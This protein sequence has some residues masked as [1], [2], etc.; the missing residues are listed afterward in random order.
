ME[1]TWAWIAGSF[2]VFFSVASS[3]MI[4]VGVF[5]SIWGFK[6]KKDTN[7]DLRKKIHEDII[8]NFTLFFE[9]LNNQEKMK[10]S[11]VDIKLLTHFK[12]PITRKKYR[13]RLNNLKKLNFDQK[14]IF[15]QFRDYKNI[16]DDFY[17]RK[18]LSFNYFALKN[19]IINEKITDR[20]ELIF[21]LVLFNIAFFTESFSL[22]KITNKKYEKIYKHIYKICK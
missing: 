7:I 14:L 8:N 22:I 21:I 15:N 10:E 16:K 5:F 19:K 18:N 11:S 3:I 20:R 1:S 2:L 6:Y 13:D 12:S 4:F 9:Y 17:I